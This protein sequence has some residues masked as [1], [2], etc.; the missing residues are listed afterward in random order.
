LT[1]TLLTKTSSIRAPPPTNPSSTGPPL[2]SAPL[3]SAPP[4]KASST[5]TSTSRPASDGDSAAQEAAESASTKTAEAQNGGFVPSSNHRVNKLVWFSTAEARTY[6]PPRLA[7]SRAI[8]YRR[9]P[10]NKDGHAVS[11][12]RSIS[13]SNTLH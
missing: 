7:A 3:T 6:G 11:G 8:G 10:H 2:T 1:N 4:A 13:H 5:G 9:R 12:W